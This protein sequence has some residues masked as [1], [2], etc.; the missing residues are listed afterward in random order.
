MVR[1]INQADGKV[2]IEFFNQKTE[3]ADTLQ[4]IV[5]DFEKEHPNIDVKLTTVPSAGIVLKTRILSGDVPDIVN[6]YP[7]N[8][9]FQEWAKSRLL[10]RYDRGKSYLENIKNDYAEKYAIE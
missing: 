2:T 4:R 1:T 8:M 5:D 6:I 9:D 3:M 10:C 7:Q